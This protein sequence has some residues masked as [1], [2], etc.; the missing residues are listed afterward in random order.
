MSVID[1]IHCCNKAILCLGSNDVNSIG[2]E[3]LNSLD[4]QIKIDIDFQ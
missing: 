3:V 2:E 4:G 1:S